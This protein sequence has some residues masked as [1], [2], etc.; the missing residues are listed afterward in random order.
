MLQ[1]DYQDDK[2]TGV[3]E[4]PEFGLLV[5]DTTTG[6]VYDTT[7]MRIEG[8]DLIVSDTSPHT[9]GEIVKRIPMEHIRYI[10][11]KEHTRDFNGVEI[12]LTADIPVYPK[13]NMITAMFKRFLKSKNI[14]IVPSD[15]R[16]TIE[17]HVKRLSTSRELL[18]AKKCLYYIDEF[19][20]LGIIED[21]EFII[22]EKRK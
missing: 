7:Y 17:K 4:G 8:T 18:S 16:A 9:A 5:V 11:H 1:L 20:A 19:I 15:K 12:I 13:D 21:I 22:R 10:K 6:T 3:D 2:F 14:L